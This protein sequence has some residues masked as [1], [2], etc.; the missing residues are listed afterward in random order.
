MGMQCLQQSS[1]LNDDGYILIAQ[2]KGVVLSACSFTADIVSRNADNAG[3]M[4]KNLL[5]ANNYRLIISCFLVV[6][7]L[8]Q[9][10]SG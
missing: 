9:K 2:K 4:S 7:V 3:F 1:S 8:L 6:V 10:V 5:S